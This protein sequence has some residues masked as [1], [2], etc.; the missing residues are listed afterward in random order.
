MQT[1]THIVKS[2]DGVPIHYDVRGS[3]TPALVFVHG[4]CGN[5]HVWDHQM[6]HF[7]PHY[8]V[9]R[10]DLAG[11][12]ASGRGRTQWTIPAF[13]QDVAAVTEQLG[14][15]GIVLIGHS[16]GGRV[17]VE[18]ARRLPDAVIGLVGV[19]T[20]HDIAHPQTPAQVAEFLVPFRA[21]F[22]GTMRAM[23]S[24]LVAPKTDPSRIQDALRDLETFPPEIAIAV[25]EEYATYERTLRERIQQVTCPKITI[26]STYPITTDAEALQA[27]GVDVLFMSSVGHMVMIED[28]QAFNRLLYEAVERVTHP[29]A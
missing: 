5:R 26:N 8:T 11:H 29:M 1:Q 9:V 10:L 27:C 17:I 21:D 7:A 22:V 24:N 3:R 23:A 25:W 19:E 16:I 12:G 15:E 13:G 28:P 4:W 14:L 20:W 18:A 6:V 2:A